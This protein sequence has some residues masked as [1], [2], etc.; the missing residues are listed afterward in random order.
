[1]IIANAANPV[2]ERQEVHTVVHDLIDGL[3]ESGR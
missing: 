2:R 3:L 1:M